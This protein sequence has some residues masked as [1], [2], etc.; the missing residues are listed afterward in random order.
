M[1]KASCKLLDG[2]LL[3]TFPDITSNEKLRESFNS[4]K[5]LGKAVLGLD[6]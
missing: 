3:R 4:R 5:G 1:R 6:S 2:K